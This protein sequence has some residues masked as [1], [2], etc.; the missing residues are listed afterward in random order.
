MAVAATSC[1]RRKHCCIRRS[2]AVF[3]EHKRAQK[4]QLED[5]TV[6]RFSAFKK[7]FKLFFAA[8]FEFHLKRL[9]V[10][11]WGGLARLAAWH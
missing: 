9:H 6:Q 2:V 11:A 8:T 1:R 7:S 10:T 3:T 4:L 5:A